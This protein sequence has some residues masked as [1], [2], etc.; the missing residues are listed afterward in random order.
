MQA[1]NHCSI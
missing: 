1:V